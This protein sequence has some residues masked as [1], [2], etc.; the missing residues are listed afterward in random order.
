M[1]E[2]YWWRHYGDFSPG[3]GILPHMGEVI[4]HY[5]KLRYPTQVEFAAA[6]GYNL[7]TVQEWEFI[8]DVS[9]MPH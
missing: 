6:S 2:L 9:C 3:N 1:S 4:S 8:T 5:R 7:R